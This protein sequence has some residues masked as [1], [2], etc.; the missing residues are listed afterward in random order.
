MNARFEIS[1]KIEAIGL[2]TT[3]S[4][5]NKKCKAV[6]VRKDEL[7]RAFIALLMRVQF[8]EVHATLFREVVT[9]SWKEQVERS[10]NSEVLANQ[11]LE[12]LRTRKLRLIDAMLDKR[13]SQA[14][15]EDRLTVLDKDILLAEAELRDAQVDDLEIDTLLRFAES[16]LSN[17]AQL[18]M[19]SNIDQKLI[20][21]KVVFPGGVSYSMENGFGTP[22]SGCL[23]NQLGE[24]VEEFETLAS[25]TGFEPVLPPWKGV[26]VEQL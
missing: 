12:K 7:E 24:I 21:Q 26:T 1:L 5:H 22:A 15:Y 14:D 16:V 25:P 9:S 4:R 19:E 20:V 17:V 11:E 6:S 10:R 8:L 13:P 2:S 18:W 23:F 3:Y